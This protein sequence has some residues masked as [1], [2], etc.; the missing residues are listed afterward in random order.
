[1]CSNNLKCSLVKEIVSNMLG[2]Q[3]DYQNRT[4]YGFKEIQRSCLSIALY[5]SFHQQT[6]M[7]VFSLWDV[8]MRNWGK[9]GL[10]DMAPARV[11]DDFTVGVTS[12]DVDLSDGQPQ[13]DSPVLS[14]SQG[15]YW[16][17][18]LK[19]TKR[20]HKIE[21]NF[22]HGSFLRFLVSSPY[23]ASQCIFLPRKL[24]LDVYYK[25]LS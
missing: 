20:A 12:R 7:S 13:R 8:C 5:L 23:L 15:G 18:K 16:R 14:H 4:Q 21:Q 9:S 3:L 19:L 24:N 22:L 1:M 2:V 17:V 6:F 10:L 11:I 25:L